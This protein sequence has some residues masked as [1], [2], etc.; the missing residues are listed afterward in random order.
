[1]RAEPGGSALDALFQPP[2]IAFVGASDSSL[3][4]RSIYRSLRAVGYAGQ[5]FPVNPRRET[6]FDLPCYPTVSAVPE[7]VGLA[8][9][10]I[11]AP[12]VPAVLAECGRRGTR[13]ALVC[14]TGFADA[15]PAGQALAEE[16]RGVC[17]AQGIL[18]CGPGS[19]GLIAGRE[20]TAP[21]WGTPPELFPGANV[22]LVAQSGGFA[23]VLV[24]VA[25][26]RGLGFSYVIAS[27]SEAVLS[28]TDYLRHFLDDEATHVIAAVVEQFR[29]VE[30]LRQ[31]A[32]LAAERE[33]PFVVLK[34]GRSER[35]RRA[36]LAHSGSLAG[37][38]A[39]HAAFFR[40]HGII[41][42]D[43]LDE[44][45]ETLVLLSAWQGRLPRGGGVGLVTI[46]GGD[47]VLMGDLADQVGLAVPELTPATQAEL[48]R[49]VPES[50]M[51]AN[52]VDAGTQPLRDGT[53]LAT[54]FLAVARDPR[55]AIAAARLTGGVAGFEQLAS[56]RDQIDKPLVLFTRA[57]QNV[58]P[59]VRDL[60]RAT[61][62][63]FLLEIERS[64]RAI[65]GAVD[66][67][68][69]L[70]ARRAAPA[71]GPDAARPDVARQ[72]ESA[73]LLGAH[74]RTLPEHVGL[75]LLARYGIPCAATHFARD[76][77][78]AVAAA[79]A[80]GYP[81]AL[82]IVSPDVV[83]K[84]DVGGVRV[85]LDGDDAVRAAAEAMLRHLRAHLPDARLDGL[86]VQEM[87]RGGS[88]VYL[89]LTSDPQLGAGVLF[90]LGGVFVE[91]LQD[92]ALRLVPLTRDDAA[93]MLGEVRGAA[94][95]AGARGRPP[96]D[97]AA[98]GDAL[99]SFSQLCLELA[100][101]LAAVDVNP[102]VVLP[103]GQGVKAVDCAFVLAAPGER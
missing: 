22:G 70:E 46:S 68:T 9:I 43:N 49:L 30:G 96:A 37:G 61:G 25:A 18:L 26:E 100:P 91:V 86:L 27:G 36:A 13:A 79:R 103:E 72:R 7:P 5:V 28:A 80:I 54:T 29:D 64:F 87:V 58:P 44:L 34:V 71:G 98:L 24:E 31:V 83:H 50:A 2:S 60:S 78:E 40:Q 51:L 73:A 10:G 42:V 35:G 15:G 93:R 62:V 1:V 33:K 21:F 11:P 84:S 75:E 77:A 6:V 47:T 82:K 99:V 12:A 89:G 57:S 17:A 59:A 65:R 74:A 95:L 4:F 48:Q 52:P 32:A 8:V 66:Y 85:D 20:R 88:E 45:V 63:P 19:F 41:A 67:A 97:R 102:L 56:I 53:G 23:N 14:S 94:V 3:I 81:V 90:G 39:F 92:T 76:A 16:V 38:H 55:V 69:Y 101:Y